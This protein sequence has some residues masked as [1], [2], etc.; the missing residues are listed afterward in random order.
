MYPLLRKKLALIISIATSLLFAFAPLSAANATGADDLAWIGTSSSISG[1]DGLLTKY[2][3]AAAPTAAVP[4]PLGN[5]LATDNTS[6]YFIRSGNLVKSNLDGSGITTVLANLGGQSPALSNVLGMTLSG[7]NLYLIDGTSGVF[8]IALS[9]SSITK[10]NNG[11][12]SLNGPTQALAAQLIV[13]TSTTVY[14]GE[15]DGLHN[16]TIGGT[17]GTEGT[18]KPNSDFDTL[19]TVSINGFVYSLAQEADALAISV[20]NGSGP[21]YLFQKS[22]SGTWSYTSQLASANYA[23]GLAMSPTTIYY[24]DFGGSVFSVDKNGANPA[25]V[26]SYSNDSEAIVYVNPA[27]T[28]PAPSPSPSTPTLP[29]TGNKSGTLMLLSG[30]LI[31]CGVAISGI[32]IRRRRKNS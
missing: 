4:A 24:T 2:S 6:L 14:W 31:L 19:S 29:N 22:A 27:V 9:N 17:P 3:G 28:P 8:R 20:I 25:T 1:G 21:A 12:I 5:S 13:A 15:S 10:I 16:W 26:F 32:A 7:T 11:G 30:S 18:V 23:A